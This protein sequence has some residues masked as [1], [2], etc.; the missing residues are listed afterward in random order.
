MKSLYLTLSI[1]CC[2]ALSPLVGL[3]SSGTVILAKGVVTATGVDNTDRV[4]AKGASVKEGD[5][6]K[7][8]MKSFAVIRMLDN[9]K[10]TLK[11]GT[12]LAIGQFSLEKG[13]EEACINLI[14]G[15]LRTVTGIIGKRK[16]D[17]FQVDTPIASIGIRGTDFIT[18]ICAGDECLADE[19]ENP[20][21]E[22]GDT[23][24]QN[25]VDAA[26]A[27]N[28]SLPEGMYGSCETGAIVMS[29]CAGQSESFEVGKCRTA[30]RKDCTVVALTPGQAG[31]TGVPVVQVSKTKEES[32]S[33]K[34]SEKDSGESKTDPV[35]KGSPPV[36]LSKSPDILAK[37]PYFKLSNLSDQELDQVDVFPDSLSPTST[38]GQCSI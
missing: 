14:R 9:T 16:P 10:L 22:F 6:I 17:S 19:P 20:L 1:I 29:Q 38:G 35:N 7:T 5:V 27:I 12:T 18:L 33:S 37:D 11:P 23:S 4:L 36:I 28:D 31:Y 34:S 21:G 8:S 2:S 30:Q 24:E 32:D 3:A 13:K 26:E 15:G 25:K